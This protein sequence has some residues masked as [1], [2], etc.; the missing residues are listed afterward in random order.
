MALYVSADLAQR[1]TRKPLLLRS[2]ENINK[3]RRQ[4]TKTGCC[5]FYNLAE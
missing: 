5:G 2:G 3:G 1:N 4:K